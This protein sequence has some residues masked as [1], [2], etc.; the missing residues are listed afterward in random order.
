VF[1]LAYGEVDA[2]AHIGKQ[3]HY[4]RH[5]EDVSRDLVHRY[6]NTVK[7]QITSYRAIIIMAVP[8]PTASEDHRQ[9]NLHT[10]ST[11]G[12]LPFVGTDSD[13]L[14]YTG[15]MNELLADGCSSYGFVF[16]NPFSFYTRKNGTLKYE[17]SDKC[18]HVGKSEY[19]LEQFYSL[20]NGLK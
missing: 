7:T 1:F 13:R 14:I 3:V 5:H 19:F 17:L 20:M 18:I 9:C 15:R 10:P 11:G 6:L 8:P 2:R 16:F 12:P 4:G